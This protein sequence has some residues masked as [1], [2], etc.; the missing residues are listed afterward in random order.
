M[1]SRATAH[2]AECRL[3]VS[4]L[5]VPVIGAQFPR[6]NFLGQVC[7]LMV[8]RGITFQTP[9]SPVDVSRY[10]GLLLPP[11][12]YPKIAHRLFLDGVVT[13][14]DVSTDDGQSL[15]PWQEV[16]TQYKLRGPVRRWFKEL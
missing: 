1:A 13:L 3:M 4:T 11:G 2:Q 5:A 12:V 14:D 15:T 8:E 9:G 16:R 6:N 7:R 10:I